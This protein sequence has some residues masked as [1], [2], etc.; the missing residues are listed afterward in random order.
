M[1]LYLT[2]RWLCRMQ[3]KRLWSEWMLYRSPEVALMWIYHV[4]GNKEN[5]S[6]Q[7]NNNIHDTNMPNH[8]PNDGSICCESYEFFTASWR[9]ESVYGNI[10]CNKIFLTIFHIRAGWTI[11]FVTVLLTLIYTNYIIPYKMPYTSFI[12][13]TYFNM[14]E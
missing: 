12:T 11:L 14:W 4:K 6:K 9:W 3:G 13:L 7:S 5:H 2:V 8:L 1:E 10:Y